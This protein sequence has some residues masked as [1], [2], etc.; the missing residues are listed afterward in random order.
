MCARTGESKEQVIN[1]VWEAYFPD[2]RATRGNCSDQRTSDKSLPCVSCKRR[3][4]DG[5]R[6]DRGS[7]Q[8]NF[9]RRFARSSVFHAS[10]SLID[11]CF[12]LSFRSSS[13]S[14]SILFLQLIAREAKLRD[15]VFAV[16][17]PDSPETFFVLATVSAYPYLNT[18]SRVCP[19]KVGP[20]CC[21]LATHI[22]WD[23]LAPTLRISP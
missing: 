22:Q 21:L 12:C 3:S 16:C 19:I 9:T 2:A 6:D 8:S 11:V 15:V 20:S 17:S 13:F 10:R 23:T 7:R 4:R 18:G 1:S 5:S 14:L